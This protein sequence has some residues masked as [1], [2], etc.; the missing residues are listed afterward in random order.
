MN[1]FAY[2]GVYA[3]GKLERARD[4]LQRI[5]AHEIALL[6]S[7]QQSRKWRRWELCI[8]ANKALIDGMLVQDPL[9]DDMYGSRE[10]LAHP[11]RASGNTMD[12]V[13]STL[14]QFVREWAA[15]GAE[16]RNLCYGPLLDALERHLP[17]T[18]TTRRPRVLC[19][20]SGLGRLPWE[21]ARRGYAS[22]GNEWSF[23]MLIAGNFVLNQCRGVHV[24]TL[25]PYI[26]ATSN[27][28]A[29]DDLFRP[30][31]IPDVDTSAL[32]PDADFSYT[33]GGFLEVY[34]HASQLGQWDAL[35]TC[36][37]LDTANSIVAYVRA[38]YAA[39]RPG[40]YWLNLGPLLYHYTE[41]EHEVSVELSLEEVLHV[42]RQVGFE[43]VEQRT[44]PARYTDN[45]RSMMHTHYDAEY[46]CA[47]KPGQ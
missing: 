17:L 13:C 41:L 45:A 32:A 29:V 21:C 10:Q 40:G 14:R 39:L 34:G 18:A 7:A 28:R 9:F 1:A 30:V 44:V 20:G 25:Y 4:T 46:W 12:K 15:E 16:E 31:R 6:D 47:R 5:P 38:I 3:T 26:H 24:G 19:P 22:Q 2:Y 23:L 35:L 42:A 37:F 27:V 43:L 11:T 8:A 33:A 36:F